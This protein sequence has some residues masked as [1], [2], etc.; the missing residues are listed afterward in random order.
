MGKRVEKATF[1]TTRTIPLNLFDFMVL[2]CQGNE[3]FSPLSSSDRSDSPLFLQLSIT[4]GGWIDGFSL[5][6]ASILSKNFHSF[7]GQEVPLFFSLPFSVLYFTLNFFSLFIMALTFLKVPGE[8][9]CLSAYK[10]LFWRSHNIASSF[11]HSIIN[12]ENI[13]EPQHTTTYM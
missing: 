8:R 13:C 5:Y 4:Y 1:P 11:D 2:F 12:Y 9:E 10:K 3:N 6:T 7:L